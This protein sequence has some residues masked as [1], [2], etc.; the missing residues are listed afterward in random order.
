[1]EVKFPYGTDDIPCSLLAP[2]CKLTV[3]I[4]DE[5]PVEA[6]DD[7]ATLIL[8]GE[9]VDI[10]EFDE[11]QMRDAMSVADG[12]WGVLPVEVQ[13]IALGTAKLK[14]YANEAEDT[15]VYSKAITVEGSDTIEDFRIG[16]DPY[17]T[18]ILDS[19]V[20]L[21][22]NVINSASGKI[23]TNIDGIGEI[24]VEVND[25]TI[26]DNRIATNGSI[27]Y[28]SSDQN[29]SI[30]GLSFKL[31]SITFTAESAAIIKGKI[32]LPANIGG[33]DIDFNVKLKPGGDFYGEI[34]LSEDIA[35]A[36]INITLSQAVLDMDSSQSPEDQAA[37]WKGL[38]IN[39]AKIKLPE[40]LAVGGGEGTV[41]E[42]TVS[43][44]YV[45]ASG[46]SGNFSATSGLPQIEFGGF[47]ASLTMT[48]VII[49]NSEIEEFS[50]KALLSITGP[51]SG[52]VTAQ[53]SISSDG[54]I[55]AEGQADGSLAFGIDVI[56]V[57]LL[58]V[59]VG[60]ESGIGWVKVSGNITA[61]YLSTTGNITINGLKITSTGLFSVESVG[62]GVNV[63]FQGFA[64]SI[65]AM[66]F[67]QAEGQ[68]AELTINGT[69]SITNIFS[70]KKLDITVTPGPHISIN[71][72]DIEVQQG[73]VKLVTNISYT[74]EI[75]KF[76]VSCDL[77]AFSFSAEG[78][79]GVQ[80]NTE[81]FYV[82]V[83]AGVQI[84]IGSSGLSFFEF[85][86]GVAY[87][88]DPVLKQPAFGAS[89][90]FRLG[91]LVKMGNTLPVPGGNVVMVRG[92]VWIGGNTLS[93]GAE[94]WLLNRERELKASGTLVFSAVNQ[95]TVSGNISA[96]VRIGYQGK[97]V[98][99][100]PG[101]EFYFS[102]S[103]WYIKGTS[104]VRVL[105]AL[106]GNATIA[107]KTGKL[108]LDGT[109]NYDTGRR[110]A[111]GFCGQFKASASVNLDVVC[112]GSCSI[113]SSVAFSGM[114]KVTFRSWTLLEATTTANLTLRAL[115]VKITG[116]ISVAY[117]IPVLPNGTYV[118]D[119]KYPI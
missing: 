99:A 41:P 71:Q 77:K 85:G 56:S 8:S 40:S 31:E 76:K 109:L 10:I 21:T 25:V 16:S 14:V 68:P 27:T 59:E 48:S 93:L 1:M 117:S 26:D 89:G 49:Q 6:G 45:S 24:N 35:I 105:K 113:S 111:I 95:P 87:N 84:P 74:D 5:E 118:F 66:N 50:L 103:N 60:I 51:F 98:K 54:T 18:V 72:I 115:P 19:P 36:Q 63:K 34:T 13:G 62:G 7:V 11:E 106:N 15:V 108:N 3:K 92:V 30:V 96:K 65:N 33:A 78:E 9:P 83:A 2:F 79:A 55:S 73:P 88:Y 67:E 39:S 110:C 52:E 94:G 112:T 75:F 91:A 46:L 119:L 43:D 97:T 101:M 38:Y 61:D 44:F 37:D 32:T 70:L 100:D 58:T 4:E 82:L 90:G 29:F 42:I 64:L 28:D 47:Q 114:A 104:S 23:E 22:D 80:G 17:F 12:Y 116:R 69:L 53:I 107:I 57:E 86:G 81:Y 102:S 20:T